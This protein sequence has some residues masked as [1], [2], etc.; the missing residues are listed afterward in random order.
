[1]GFCR[2]EQRG[3]VAGGEQ[4][5][6]HCGVGRRRHRRRAQGLAHA[7]EAAL[8]NSQ[9]AGVDRAAFIA[10]GAV[11]AGVPLDFHDERPPVPS[12]AWK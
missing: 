8:P 5:V 9:V 4:F 7:S 11:A 6:R 2:G 3:E 10:V 1:M 12:C